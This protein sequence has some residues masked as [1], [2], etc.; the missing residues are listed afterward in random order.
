MKIFHFKAMRSSHENIFSK[1]LL[2]LETNKRNGDL[3]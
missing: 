1:S 3:F 2:D